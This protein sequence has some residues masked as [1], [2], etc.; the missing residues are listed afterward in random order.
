VAKDY[1]L[2]AQECQD[3]TMRQAG[4][5]ESHLAE[6]R[7]H[8]TALNSIRMLCRIEGATLRHTGVSLDEIGSQLDGFQDEIGRRL[9]RI[10]SLGQQVQWAT[11]RI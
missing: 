3:R 1:S 2:K 9:L 5:V 7:K 10:T 11:S 4:T 6:M 8:V